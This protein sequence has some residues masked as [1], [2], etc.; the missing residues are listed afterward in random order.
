MLE[1]ASVSP[2]AGGEMVTARHPYETMGPALQ[3]VIAFELNDESL[4]R[5]GA[6]AQSLAVLLERLFTVA[7]LCVV[8]ALIGVIAAAESSPSANAALAG[9]LHY[10]VK[11]HVD[12]LLALLHIHM[13]K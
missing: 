12:A 10:D 13:Q 11:A 9:F 6:L 3:P 1:V 5:G 7:L 2:V 4:S 8:F